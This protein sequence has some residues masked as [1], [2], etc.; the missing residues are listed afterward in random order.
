MQMNEIGPVSYRSHKINLKWMKDFNIKCESIKILEE[1]INGKFLDITVGNYFLD[2]VPK[3]QATK[4]KSK[5]D[6]IKLKSS[7]QQKKMKR[8][9]IGWEKIFA[10]HI[11]DKGLIPKI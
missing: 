7:A 4:A 6:Y 3:A 2:M 10:N 9:P 8:Q 1:N 5:W 11:S